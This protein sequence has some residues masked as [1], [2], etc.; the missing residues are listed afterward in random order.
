MVIELKTRLLII[1]SLA[2]I[3]FNV[4][5]VSAVCDPDSMK[6]GELCLDGFSTLIIEPHEARI[7]NI[8]GQL[9][10][11]IGPF[12]LERESGDRIRLDDVTFTYPSYP[13]PPTPG[14]PVSVTITFENGSK[15][16]IFK[17]GAP[18]PFIEFVGVDPQ[19]G[20]RRNTNGSFDYLLS[21][22]QRFDSQSKQF[23]TGIVQW[24]SRCYSP[25]ETAYVTVI[26]RD[27]N[28][29][30]AIRDG[31]QITVWSD[32]IEKETGTNKILPVNVLETGNSTGI[33]EGIVFLGS[34]FDETSGHRVPV[35]N[36]NVIFAKYLDYTPSDHS[37]LL[38]IVKTTTGKNL[39]FGSTWDNWERSALLYG[40]PLVYEPCMKKQ[41]DMIGTD[42]NF[43]KI[44]VI[45]P[46]P[47]KQVESGLYI[48]ETMCKSNLELI[49]KNNGFH[50]CVKS[51]TIPRL[52]ERGWATN[53]N[54]EGPSSRSCYSDPD[55][56]LC[57]AAIEKYYFDSET[58]SCKSFIWG[59]YGGNVPFDTMGLCQNMCN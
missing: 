13:N 37:N 39:P 6:P 21:F 45:Y 48:D 51:D 3:S 47:I 32:W 22:E 20:V 7:E 41:M 4:S 54:L 11:V 23:Q 44:D 40:I 2:L 29:D 58:N 27:M 52:H 50:Y 14:G 18:S 1:I 53:A 5:N 12:T 8:D 59:G 38:E 57:K 24:S 46:A 42:G 16:S 19:A 26:D 33:F 43:E 35:G 25:S 56:G 34:A 10:H 17:V 28:L 15:E 30:P 55:V 31:F 9:F 49:K 36:D